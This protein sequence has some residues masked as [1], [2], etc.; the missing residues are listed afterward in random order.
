[1]AFSR[2]TALTKIMKIEKEIH[3]IMNSNDFNKINENIKLLESRIG[4]RSIQVVS[5]EDDKLLNLRRNSN[6]AMEINENSHLQRENYLRKLEA[7]E[8][9]KTRLK[10]ELFR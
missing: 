3:D 6:R 9:E 1:M 7:L 5:P 4:S 2:R 8:N 10:K